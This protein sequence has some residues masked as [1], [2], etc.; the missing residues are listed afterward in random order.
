MLCGQVKVGKPHQQERVD[1]IQC[2]TEGAAPAECR[3]RPRR[4]LQE[5]GANAS[6]SLPQS[7][8][9]STRVPT[10]P[11][12]TN[13]SPVIDDGNHRN[14]ADDEH[15]VREGTKEIEVEA[16]ACST[17]A[18]TYVYTRRPRRA[19]S[20]EPLTPVPKSC[21]MSSTDSDRH[22]SPRSAHATV[23][24]ATRA[25]APA[26]RQP[27]C[28]QHAR[29]D[30]AAATCAAPG[31]HDLLAQ[32]RPCAHCTMSDPSCCSQKHPHLGAPASRRGWYPTAAEPPIGTSGCVSVLMPKVCTAVQY[33]SQAQQC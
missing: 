29:P 15:Q 30:A 27:S 21:P 7:P 10:R 12:K 26:H 2:R 23:A 32:M 33:S 3:T 1:H 13:L 22:D 28:D 9:L 11:R 31:P 4:R 17:R 8:Q 16:N 18:H 19:H 5:P 24:P 6:A 25:G 20:Q 14:A